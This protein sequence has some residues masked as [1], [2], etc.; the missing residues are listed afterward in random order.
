MLLFELFNFNR[1]RQ[2]YKQTDR[3]RAR[4]LADRQIDYLS[5][6]VSR[7]PYNLKLKPKAPEADRQRVKL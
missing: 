6:K 1:D 7:R 3:Q 2:A 4:K 5:T